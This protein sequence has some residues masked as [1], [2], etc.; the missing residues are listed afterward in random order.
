MKLCVKVPASI[1]N[2]G[3]G[4]DSFAIAIKNPSEKVTVTGSTSDTLSIKI[5]SNGQYKVPVEVE[6]NTAGI[7]AMHYLKD[8]GITGEFTIELDK[9]IMPSGGLGSS[10]ASAAGTLH[11]LNEMFHKMDT[12]QLIQYASM[13]ERVSSGTVHHDN[14]SASV[15]GGL[16]IND[17]NRFLKVDVAEFSVA[18]VTPALQLKTED[19]RKVLGETVPVSELKVHIS[20]SSLLLHAFMIGDLKEIG[21]YVNS[22]NV[23]EKRRAKLI[24]GYAE[25][26]KAA[27]INGAYGV[28]IS[29]S[30][31]SMF[32]IGH[33][34]NLSNVAAAMSEAFKENGLKSTAIVTETSNIGA[35]VIV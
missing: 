33:M 31:P 16:V 3:P 15:L 26:K 14:V 5:I 35:T 29:G 7:S 23:V 20:A 28:A 8:K 4:F 17:G 25:V 21:K 1:A 34:E 12:D 19:S 11:A 13:G 30:G 18:V 9:G 22:E 27:L 32:A 6:K 2:L 10:A 24:P